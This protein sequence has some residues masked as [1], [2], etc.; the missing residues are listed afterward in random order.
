MVNQNKLPDQHIAESEIA[1]SK[2]ECQALQ[3]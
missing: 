1:R 2:A 3:V